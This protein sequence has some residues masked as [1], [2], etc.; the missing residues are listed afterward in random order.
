MREIK[1]RQALFDRN[2]EFTGWHY[3]GFICDGQFVGVELGTSNHKQALGHSYQYTG[4]KDKNEVEIYEGD[5]V[6]WY[7]ETIR[8]M[9]VAWDDASAGFLMQMPIL[10]G[11]L[12]WTSLEAE[13]VEV[14]GNILN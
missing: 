14:I 11:G 12:G 1:F 8:I 13:L 2:G 9:E 5:I 6:K 4:L 3:W 7:D 10:K